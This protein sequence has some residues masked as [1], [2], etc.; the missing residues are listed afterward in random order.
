MDGSA[1]AGWVAVKIAAEAALRA[2]SVRPTALLAYLESQSTSFDGHK[3]WPLS[4]RS[5]DHQLRQPL[6]VVAPSP[7]AREGTQDIP[8]LGALAAGGANANQLLDALM[9][10]SMPRCAWNRT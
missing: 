6:Y 10:R 1:W 7:K 4:F 5:T 9:P 8:A 3:G 2:R